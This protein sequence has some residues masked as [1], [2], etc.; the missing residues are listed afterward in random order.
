MRLGKTSKS[1]LLA[2]VPLFAGL[3]KKELGEVAAIADEISLPAGRRLIEEGTRGREFF[4]LVEG[5]AAVSRK[6]RKI[7]EV[8]GGSWFGEIALVADVPRT[9][10]VTATSAVRLLVVTEHGFRSLIQ[11]VPGIAVKVLA[12]VGERLAEYQKSI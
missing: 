12:T 7:N 8:E 1:D 3:S 4:V 2:A 11:R 10:T 5:T 9:A 6:G